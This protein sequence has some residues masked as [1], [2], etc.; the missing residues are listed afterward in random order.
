LGVIENHLEFKK[1]KR[2]E[3]AQISE[4]A[5]ENAD[6]REDL[7]MSMSNCTSLSERIGELRE[8]TLELSESSRQGAVA[9]AQNS[10]A[11]SNAASANFEIADK[12]AKGEM[13][14]LGEQ[15]EERI[16]AYKEQFE[17]RN[18]RLNEYYVS[19]SVNLT[20]ALGGVA[21]V[22]LAVCGAVTNEV[23]V[24]AGV[25]GGAGCEGK[26]GS[27]GSECGG[28]MEAYRG[29]VAARREFA[30]LY[31]KQEAEF[32]RVLTKV[33]VASTRLGAVNGDVE[34]LLKTTT[35]S[36]QSLR[37]ERAKVDGLIGKMKAFAD[38]NDEKP[39]QISSVRTGFR[40]VVKSITFINNK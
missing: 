25:C 21:G 18:K 6:I 39:K 1:A 15:L 35:G 12:L 28:L 13:A 2:A 37:V 26:C 22:N 19:V 31:E 29:A 3:Y 8:K 40:I 5:S 11:V 4:W 24:C 17:A 34:N 36:L 10:A 14:L 30:E 7:T 33:H 9:S 16:K 38:G 27:N 32:K 23:D 20:D